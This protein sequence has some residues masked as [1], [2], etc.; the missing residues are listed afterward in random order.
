[1][2]IRLGEALAARVDEWASKNGA[3]SRSDAI[4]R[5]LD[6]ALPTPKAKR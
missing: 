6:E 5:L 3:D 2:S 1:M 4:R